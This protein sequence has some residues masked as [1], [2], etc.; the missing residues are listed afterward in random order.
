[1]WA[2]MGYWGGGGYGTPSQLGGPI[3]FSLFGSDNASG[4]YAGVGASST[5]N[6][7][8]RVTDTAG[9]GP[10]RA[11]APGLPALGSRAGVNLTADGTRLLDLNAIQ[12]LL[13]G[14]TLSYRRSDMDFGTS[15]L[16][17]GVTS[18]GSVRRS[19]YTLA[20]T[21]DYTIDTIYFSGYAAVDWS[22]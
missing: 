8:Y 1:M 11:P 20:G 12:Q 17:P 18:A 21:V 14:V 5:W 2:G 15:V 22:H 13:F 7:G 3:Q 4:V 16:T 9:G 6:S 10:A 19:G